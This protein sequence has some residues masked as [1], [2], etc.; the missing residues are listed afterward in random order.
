MMAIPNEPPLTQE[1]VQQLVLA[2]RTWVEWH[3]APDNPVL[4]FAGSTALTPRQ[5]AREVGEQS[6]DGLAFLRLVHFGLEVMSFD[7]ILQ[8]FLL[9]R[10]PG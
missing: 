4:S 9:P 7:E 8:G 2:L 6:A 3:P 5:L 10:S 1:Q